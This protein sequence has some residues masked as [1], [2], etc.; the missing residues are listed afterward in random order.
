MIIVPPMLTIPNQLEGAY[1]GQDVAL[2]CHTEAYPTSIN[3]WTTEKGDMIIS[4]SGTKRVYNSFYSNTLFSLLR[5][6]FCFVLLSNNC[7][8]ISCFQKNCSARL[9]FFVSFANYLFIFISLLKTFSLCFY[10]H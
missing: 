3:Y 8:R 1:I 4:G 10:I 9:V 7:C 6:V 2:E 5:I